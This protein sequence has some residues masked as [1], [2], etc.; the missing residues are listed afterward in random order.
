LD[1]NEN[2]AF[3]ESSFYQEKGEEPFIEKGNWEIS[4]DGIIKLKYQGQENRYFA[5]RDVYIEMLDPQ[6]KE[7]QSALK[8]KY[9]LYPK[10]EQEEPER[11][12][13]GFWNE[14]SVRGVDF[15]ASGNEPF[16]SLEIDFEKNLVLKLLGEEEISVSAPQQSKTP[17]AANLQ[18]QKAIPNGLLKITITRKECSDNMS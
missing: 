12:D 11:P 18:Y 13:A 10:S 15:F 17:G 3:T 2:G 9:R 5:F 4:P 7:I 8:E 14:K 6:G 16:W 1:L